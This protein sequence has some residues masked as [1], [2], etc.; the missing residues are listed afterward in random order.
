[1][2]IKVEVLGQLCQLMKLPKTAWDLSE[3]STVADLLGLLD[4]SHRATR[5]PLMILV[6]KRLAA[7]QVEL[8]EGDQVT[9]LLPVGGG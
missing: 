3:G 5:L 6:N 9:L 7:P 4:V 8:T 2:K 1:M